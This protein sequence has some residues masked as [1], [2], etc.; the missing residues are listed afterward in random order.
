MSFGPGCWRHRPWWKVAVNT[1]L[2]FVQTRRRPARL[3]V[4][5][6]QCE[7]GDDITPPRVLGYKLVKVLHL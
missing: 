1:F 5:A 3:L 2:R 4:V 7:D 6:T